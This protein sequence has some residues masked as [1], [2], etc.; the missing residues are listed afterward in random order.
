M[1]VTLRQL[2]VFIEVARLQ[3]F[4]RAGDE[5]GLTQSAVSRCVRELE[6][7]IGLKLIDRTTREVQL[8]DVGGNLVSSVS[9]L[10]TDLDDALREIREIGEQRRGR[11]VVA[12]SPTV[13]CRLMPRVVAS[14]GQQFPYIALGLRD[15]V[16]SDVVRKVKSGEVDFGVIIGPFSAD[17]LL[18]ESLMTDS[19]CVVS[20]DDHPLAAK[21]RVAWTDLDGQQLVMLDYAS[22]SRPIIDAAMQ[23]YGVSATVVQEL[24][25]S[26]TVFGLVEAGVGVSVLPWLALPLPAGASLVARPLVPRAE[27]TV[28]LVRRRDRSLSP[29][30]EAVWGLIRQLP[31]RAEDLS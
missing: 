17:D 13:A 21:E 8:T 31:G 24:G 28:E 3:S 4:S 22:G 25:H 29:A 10:L 15:D 14:C 9:R 16:Q 7:E 23:E 26:A 18:S 6:G 5:I 11:V 19:F 30:A 12:A 20:R 27:R 2:R 1:N